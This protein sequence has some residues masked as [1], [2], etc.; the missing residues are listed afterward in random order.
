LANGN[1]HGLETGKR[2]KKHLI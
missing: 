2:S 1:E